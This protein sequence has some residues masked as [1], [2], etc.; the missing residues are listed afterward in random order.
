VT[1]QRHARQLPRRGT[2][3]GA[4]CAHPRAAPTGAEAEGACRPYRVQQPTNAPAAEQHPEL[5]SWKELCCLRSKRRCASL[6]RSGAIKIPL[7][8]SGLRPCPARARAR[9]LSLPLVHPMLS[10]HPCHERARARSG[11]AR[12]AGAGAGAFPA[13]LVRSGFHALPASAPA[14]TLSPFHSLL[15]LL[16]R[17]DAVCGAAA[18]V[19]PWGCST[20]ACFA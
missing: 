8:G 9:A 7:L 5:R 12:R 17:C 14:L 20:Q 15:G 11:S 10:S 1:R 3:G 13:A 16:R 18:S 4:A 6:T 2:L 19:S